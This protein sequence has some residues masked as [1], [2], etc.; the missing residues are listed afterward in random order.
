MR[1]LNAQPPPPAQAEMLRGGGEDVRIT[2]QTSWRPLDPP[3]QEPAPSPMCSTLALRRRPARSAARA[4]SRTRGGSRQPDPRRRHPCRP[5]AG[6]DRTDAADRPRRSAPQSGQSSSPAPARAHRDRLP[7]PPAPPGHVT[8][9]C[10][11]NPVDVRGSPGSRSREAAAR[12]VG[13]SSELQRGPRG[14]RHRSRALAGVS[15]PRGRN[16]IPAGGTSRSGAGDR[17]AEQR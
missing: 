7:H 6:A 1:V 12:P 3:P 17:G 2:S 10:V 13:W 4:C 5:G 16:P 15:A 14:P 11:G 9:P 8:D